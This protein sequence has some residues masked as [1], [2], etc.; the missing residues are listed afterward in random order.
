V[1]INDAYLA[2]WFYLIISGVKQSTTF[3]NSFAPIL[4][5][6]KSTNIMRQKAVEDFFERVSF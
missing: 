2:I 5:C 3:A 1:T 4:R 6:V